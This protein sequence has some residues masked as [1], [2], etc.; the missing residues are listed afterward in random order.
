MRTVHDG[1]VPVQPF[2]HSL[3]ALPGLGVAVRRTEV[4]F[5]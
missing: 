5:A 2:R 3:N 1:L 4:L